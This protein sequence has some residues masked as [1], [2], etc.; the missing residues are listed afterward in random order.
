MK[1]IR[2]LENKIKIFSLLLLVSATTCS[3]DIA[4]KKLYPI[5]I[6]FFEK[7]SR[8]FHTEEDLIKVWECNE[9]YVIAVKTRYDCIK[10]A[11]KGFKFW[12]PQSQ[13]VN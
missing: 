8:Y 2:P 13:P 5:E 3:S 1:A 4:Y 9:L 6:Y 7:P 11:S 10:R 12:R